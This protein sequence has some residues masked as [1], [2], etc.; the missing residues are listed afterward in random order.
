MLFFSTLTVTIRFDI[1]IIIALV[2]ITELQRITSK[3]NIECP[4]D[5]IPYNCSI[6]SNSETIHLIWRVTLPGQMPFNITYGHYT[7]LNSVDSLNYFITT[8]LTQYISDEYIESTLNMTVVADIPINQTQL[9]CFIGDLGNNSVYVSVNISGKL[10]MC[11]Y[12]TAN[13]IYKAIIIL[14]IIQ[15]PSCLLVLTTQK[16]FM[17]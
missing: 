15:Y 12:T 11:S 1:V 9:E 13:S 6:H 4:G 3:E 7:N 17:E 5:S 14:A 8:T 16:R 10:C 2:I